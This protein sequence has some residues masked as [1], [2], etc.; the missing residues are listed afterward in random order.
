MFLRRHSPCLRFFTALYPVC[1]ITLLGL[2]KSA[3]AQSPE[4]ESLEDSTVVFEAEFFKQFQPVSVNDMIDR[5]PGIGLALGRGGGGGRRGLGGGGNEILIN[6]PT[7]YRKIERQPR[8][9]APHRGQSGA[10]YRDYPG[11]SEEIDVRGGSQVINIVL[12][13]SPHARALPLKSTPI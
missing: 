10:I 2:G 13:E 7:N 12:I 6:G 1:L 4:D 5:I 8:S 9:A 11:T 3:S